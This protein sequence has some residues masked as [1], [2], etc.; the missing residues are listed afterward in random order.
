[1]SVLVQMRVRVD[2]VDRF[3]AAYEQWLPQIG[4]MGGKSIGLYTS[5]NDP[6]E[7]SLL[8]EWE[9][10]DHMHEASE[11]YGDQFNETPA[12]RKGL[13]DSNLAQ[14]DLRPCGPRATRYP[15]RLVSSVDRF[16]RIA[17]RSRTTPGRALPE[18]LNR[19]RGGAAG[20][21]GAAPG[22][23]SSTPACSW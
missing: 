11:K 4:E 10:H 3:K 16:P 23:P 9:S 17:G 1:M 14:D 8:E 13:G 22:P 12:P 15:R 2:D 5:E 6:N 21:R 20:E 19:S 18:W 7:V